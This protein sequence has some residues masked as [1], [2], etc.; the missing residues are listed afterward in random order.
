LFGQGC[1]KAIVLSLFFVLSIT[2]LTNSCSSRQTYTE[3]TINGIRHIHNIEPLWGEDD[4]VTLEFIRKFGD[5]NTIDERYQLYRPADVAV[6]DEG[7]VFILDGANHR[8]KKYDKNGRYL[9]SF[10]EKGNGPG[11]FLG[12][13]RLDIC[14]GGDIL[15]SDRA[16]MAV[17]VFDKSGHFIRRINNEGSSPAE[18]LALRSG[19]IAVF[20][21][22]TSP[23][24]NNQ[25]TPSLINIVDKNGS[26][27]RKFAAPRIYEDLPT[28]FWCNSAAIAAD[29]ADNI[30]VNFEAQN[31]IEKYSAE[32]KLIFKADRVLGYPE[33]LTIGK[34]VYVYD[35]GPLVAVSFNIFS[36]G[37]QIDHK[38]RIWSGT[39]KRQKNPEE[40]KSS[41]NARR[42]GGRPEDYMFEIYDNN[43]VLLGRIQKEFYHGQRFRIARDRFFFIDRDVEMTVFEYR[44]V[45]TS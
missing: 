21:M 27:L 20:C 38:G 29:D 19:G 36:A 24:E 30:F 22:S 5:L 41:E 17:N 31:R 10:G 12:A 9:S 23:S 25:G 32:G 40:K 8:V 37:I 6:D 28:N 34:K 13:T 11:E 26:I 3:E 2:A 35:E 42:E 33:T 15:I 16:I 43:G 45:D 1:K 18:I 4:K 7:C 44:I 39:L 14:P